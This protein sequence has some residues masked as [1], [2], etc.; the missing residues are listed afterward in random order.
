[1]AQLAPEKPEKPEK[2]VFPT[3]HVAEAL[4]LLATGEER[5]DSCSWSYYELERGVVRGPVNA[6]TG[7]FGWISCCT[8]TS[9]QIISFYDSQH[10][11]SIGSTCM[12]T[13]LPMYVCMARCF[14][15]LAREQ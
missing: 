2:H 11:L 5:P 12:H 1:M 7:M 6:A 10:L 15:A 4:L 13:Y 8:E 3:N 9:C 14:Q